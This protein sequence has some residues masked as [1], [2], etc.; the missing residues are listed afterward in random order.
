M[1]KPLS[2]LGL[3]DRVYRLLKSG[4]ISFAWE[5]LSLGMETSGEIADEIRQ[6][7]YEVFRETR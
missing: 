6:K 1:L 5:L 2:E 7:L 4:G 3:S